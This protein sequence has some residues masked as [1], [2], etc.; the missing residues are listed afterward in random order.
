MTLMGEK[1]AGSVLD[2][3]ADN[4]RI[5]SAAMVEKA[6]SGHPGGAMGGVDFMNVL[7]SKF[8]KF[9]PNDMNWFFRDRFFLDPGHMSPM[10][11]AQLHLIGKFT[12]EELENFRQWGSP[13]HGHPEVDFLRGIENS[14]GPLGMGHAMALGAAIA[15]RVFVDRF[16]DWASHKTYTYISDGGMQEEISQGVGRIA[17]F[18]GL[19]NF[20]MFYDSNDIQLSHTTDKTINEDTA[21]KYRSWGWRVETIEGNDSKEI[22]DALIRANQEKDK[23]TLIIGKT[24]MGKGAVTPAGDNFER[25]VSTHGQPLTNAGA[26]FAKTVEHLG[27]NPE[28]PFAV[29]D[30]VKEFYSSVLKEKSKEASALKEIQKE[31]ETKNPKLAEKMYAMISGE[32]SVRVD[33]ESFE[34]PKVCATRVSSGQVLADLSDYYNSLVVSSAD[35]SNS[36][37]TG[38]FLA[39]TTAFAH[40]QFDG[41][42]LQAGVAELTMA[43]IMNGMALHGGITPVCATFFVFS[44]YMKP[45]IRMAA[46]MEIPVKYVFTHDSFRVGEDGPTHQPVEQEAQIRLLEKMKNFSGKPSMLVLRP[47]DSAEAVVSWELAMANRT[48]PTAFILTRQNVSLLDALDGD[49]FAEAKEASKG[50]YIVKKEAKDTVDVVLVANG[51]EVGLLVDTAKEL[52]AEGKSVRVVSAISEGL[53]FEQTEEYRESV[54]PTCCVPVFGYSA[55]LPTALEKIVGPLGKVFGREAFGASAP[56]AVLDEKFGYTVDAVK[57]HL[58]EYLEWYSKMVDKIKSI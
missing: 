17:G 4:M 29:F 32:E 21:A 38:K 9:D 18:L 47:A 1:M 51:S 12:M 40:K 30:D 20:I 34:V 5:L 33:Y 37:N 46:L 43:A 8:L 41:A 11:Y 22:E 3:A 7:Y 54:I 55:G 53:F 35:L 49:R 44:D 39:R 45:A 6:K 13:T 24:V 56:A 31:W 25:Q 2:R 28:N 58:A 26:D 27:G 50:A 10:L 14:S 16:G 36:D 52:E 42:F 23:P 19:S 48:S 15:E 57:V